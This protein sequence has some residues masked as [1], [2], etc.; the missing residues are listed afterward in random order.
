[1]FKYNGARKVNGQSKNG[2]GSWKWVCWGFRPQGGLSF[3]LFPPKHTE[4]WDLTPHTQTTTQ[5]RWCL[6]KLLHY[7]ILCG[8]SQLQSASHGWGKWFWNFNT[9]TKQP[10]D[11]SGIWI[12]I[13]NLERA[14]ESASFTSSWGNAWNVDQEWWG[15]RSMV[16][17]RLVASLGGCG[18]LD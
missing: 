11:L 9:H 10:C 5:N 7:V 15:L 12:W 4:V 3:L 17:D 6:S 18:G 16:T 14:W 1:M 8:S 13:I 2:R